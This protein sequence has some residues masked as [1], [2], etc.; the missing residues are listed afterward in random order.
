M[1]SILRVAFSVPIKRSRAH[2]KAIRLQ[3]EDR[4]LAVRIGGFDAEMISASVFEMPADAGQFD[5]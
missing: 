4:S 5:A 2:L 1:A 3:S